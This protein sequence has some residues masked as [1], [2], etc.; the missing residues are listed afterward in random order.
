MNQPNCINFP[1]CQTGKL[2]QFAKTEKAEVRW[3]SS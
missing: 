2:M 1:A 3:T